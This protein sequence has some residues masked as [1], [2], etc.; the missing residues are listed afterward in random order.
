MKISHLIIGLLLLAIISLSGCTSTNSPLGNS[1]AG[2]YVAVVGGAGDKNILT[3]NADGTYTQDF[4]IG[5]SQYGQYTIEGDVLNIKYGGEFGGGITKYKISGNNFIDS[6]GN[7]FVKQGASG[8]TSYQPKFSIGDIVKSDYGGTYIIVKTGTKN[9]ANNGAY[10][11][12]TLRSV[13]KQNGE[14]VYDSS[15]DYN[16]DTAINSVD[17]TYQLVAHA[18]PSELSL[19]KNPYLL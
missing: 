18:D 8:S 16:T 15:P 9:N 14:W 6:A 19:M 3:L 7:V 1:Y 11:V 2:K 13:Q 4:P 17:K 12:Y 10:D 5:S